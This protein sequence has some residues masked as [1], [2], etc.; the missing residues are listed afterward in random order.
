MNPQPTAADR[1]LAKELLRAVPYCGC[2][3]CVDLA[4]H[5][6]ARH[7]SE[8]DAG[9]RAEI[10]RLR[11]ALHNVVVGMAPLIEHLERN[12]SV[13]WSQ[14]TRREGNTV[15]TAYGSAKRVLEAK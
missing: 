12:A 4:I 14:L 3:S 9:L 1:E 15:L 8:H 7:R 6:I 2:D 11:G 10:E 13:D 5:I